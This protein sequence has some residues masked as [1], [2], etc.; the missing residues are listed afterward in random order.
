MSVGIIIPCFNEENRLNIKAFKKCLKTYQDFQL[1]FVNE[2]SKDDTLHL[3]SNFQKE[4]KERV[5]IIDMKKN[6]GRD[7]AIRAGSRFLYSLKKIKHVGFLDADLSTDFDEFNELI[8]N[9]KLENKL[10]KV[11]RSHNYEK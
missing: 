4:F 2:G 5:S 9:L 8:D 10:I 3:L 1:C 11:S 7:S 6:I